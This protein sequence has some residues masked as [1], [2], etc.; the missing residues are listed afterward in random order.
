MR[1]NVAP[2]EVR[3]NLFH[4]LAHPANTMREGCG[5]SR[6]ISFWQ[7]TFQKIE[8]GMQPVHHRETLRV[9]GLRWR[10]SHSPITSESLNPPETA[11]WLVS[12]TV[13]M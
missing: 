5:A 6:I 9:A 13:L 7:Q 2:H 12:I 11:R 1:Q 10:R 3:R 8:V 4:V